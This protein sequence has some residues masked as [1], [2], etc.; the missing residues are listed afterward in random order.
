MES[1][2]VAASYV[3]WIIIYGPTMSLVCLSY[4]DTYLSTRDGMHSNMSHVSCHI[5]IHHV[6]HRDLCYHLVTNM[7]KMLPSLQF[8]CD[9]GFLKGDPIFK[10]K[11]KEENRQR[12]WQHIA[13]N[14]IPGQHFN[15]C[16]VHLGPVQSPGKRL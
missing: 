12:A 10:E 1:W 7:R 3:F 14:C 15:R 16:S 2:S 5:C 8:C 4:A 13:H 9:K 6:F 11:I